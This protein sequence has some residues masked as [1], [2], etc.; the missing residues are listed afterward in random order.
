LPWEAIALTILLGRSMRTHHNA[1]LPTIIA[2]GAKHVLFHADS[3]TCP[4]S[5]GFNLLLTSPPYYHPT[6]RSSKHGIGFTGELE[7]YANSVGDVLL[8]WS[9][10]VAGRRVCFVKTDVWHRGTLIPV[11]WQ[12]MRSCVERGLKLRAHWIWQRLAAFSPYGPTFSNIFVFAEDFSHP[13]FAGIITGAAVTRRKGLT[14]SFSP[15]L[16]GALIELLT[17]PH[18]VLLDPFAGA[19]GVI[20]AA[21]TH[22]R[23][24]VGIELSPVQFQL[25][26]TRLSRIPGFIF[27]GMGH[28]SDP[29]GTNGRDAADTR[30]SRWR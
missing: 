27:R 28:Q 8:H 12:I 4:Y 15:E 14:S 2:A 17:A 5:G 22:E 23:R 25:G 20:E 18:D 7:D 13:H 11:S 9:K 30:R 6:R 16:F 24:S 19:G 1:Q 10:A 21:A 3:R 26:V 29:G